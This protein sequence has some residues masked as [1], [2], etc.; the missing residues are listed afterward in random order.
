MFSRKKD[1]ESEVSVCVH[2]C[3]FLQC[4]D[5]LP[6]ILRHSQCLAPEYRWWWQTGLQAHKDKFHFL[7]QSKKPQMKGS[8]LCASLPQ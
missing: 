8:D 6:Q 1:V 4:A 3:D 5:S 2:V 7:Q